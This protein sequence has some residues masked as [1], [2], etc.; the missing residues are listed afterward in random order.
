[1][2][3]KVLQQQNLRRASWSLSR[4][5]Q[6]RTGSG[7]CRWLLPWRYRGIRD[8]VVPTQGAIPAKKFEPLTEV[9]SCMAPWPHASSVQRF[10]FQETCRV[11]KSCSND[12]YPGAR[13]PADCKAEEGRR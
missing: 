10:D 2:H 13:P 1:M 9:S 4:P 11:L 8:A 7:G 5:G 3:G 12:V 6:W